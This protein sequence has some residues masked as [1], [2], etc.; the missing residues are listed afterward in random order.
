MYFTSSWDDGHPLDMQLAEL[1]TRFGFAATL[2][3]P[4]SNR[5]GLPVL[6]RGQLTELDQQFE[7]GSHTLDHAYATHMSSQDWRRQVIDGKKALEDALGHEVQGFC[8]PGGKMQVDSR[9]I[10]VEAGFQYARTIENFW[11]KSKGDIFLMPT[12]LQFYP[13]S[14]EVLIRNFL[15]GR[16]WAARWNTWAAAMSS[17]DLQTRLRA[18]LDAVIKHDG[19]FHLWGHSWEIEALGAWDTLKEFLAYANDRV[20]P[21]ARVT[22]AGLVQHLHPA[23]SHLA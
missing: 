17:S 21:Q 7:I 9:Q 1:L 10:V 5:E 12:T 23:A 2:Y 20:P 19:V 11:D 16:Q 15:R 14:R 22:N 6:A 8:Y 4:E 3:V 18:S 13:H